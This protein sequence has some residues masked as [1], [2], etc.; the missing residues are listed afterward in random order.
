MEQ[1]PQVVANALEKANEAAD[2][3]QAAWEELNAI[4][5]ATVND[6][7]KWIRF[8]IVRM[9]LRTTTSA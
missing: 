8:V 4:E 5:T 6:I 3:S 9:R 1:L 2:A 7:E